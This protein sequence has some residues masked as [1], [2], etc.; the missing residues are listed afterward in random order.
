MCPY[1]FN[2]RINFPHAYFGFPES[3]I[4]EIKIS[5]EDMHKQGTQATT[6]KVV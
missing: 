6:D 3:E 2:I 5:L 1:S 4:E